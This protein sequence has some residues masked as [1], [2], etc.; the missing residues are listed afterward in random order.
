[1]AGKVRPLRS[2]PRRFRAVIRS[3]GANPYVS[4]PA[5]VALAFAAFARAGRIRV[6]GTLNGVPIRGSLIPVRGGAHRLFVN[7]GMR[8]AASVA[9][10]DTVAFALR[11]ESP[12]TVSLPPDVASAFARVKGARAAFEAAPPSRRR[13]LLRYVDAAQ[14]PAVRAQ[15]IRKTAAHLLGERVPAGP[16]R[17][18]RPLW[19]CPRCGKDFVNRN[20]WHS[21]RRYTVEQCF[22]GKPPSIRA[23]FDRLRARVEA[24]GPVQLVPYRDRVAFMVRVRFA[25]ATPR[26]RWLDVEF[27][28]TRRI[29]HARIR[30]TETLYPHVHLYHVRV[31]EARKIDATLIAWLRESYA[32]GRQEHLARR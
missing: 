27:W 26:S 28:L 25:G 31:T 9:V 14:S 24:F 30:R 16:G 2:A 4:V 3:G 12:D 8:S 21:C 18:N 19:T 5:P 10:G 17:G 11:A 23:L 32:V 7:G 29:E 1:M 20:Q 15:R 22:A 13:E 6:E